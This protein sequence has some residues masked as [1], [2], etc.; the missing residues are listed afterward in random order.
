ML[1]FIAQAHSLCKVLQ[2]SLWHLQFIH[3][4][5]MLVIKQIWLALSPIL[6][7]TCIYSPFIAFCFT[8]WT[9]FNFLLQSK[10]VKSCYD[11]SSSRPMFCQPFG[12][13]WAD[14]TLLEL[15]EQKIMICWSTWV[16]RWLYCQSFRPKH[17]LNFTFADCLGFLVQTT[18]QTETVQLSRIKLHD[19]GWCV[20]RLASI[21]RT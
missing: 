3:C 4:N 17:N 10:E 5:M 1:Q 13:V 14:I 20:I 11:G 21:I 19:A 6:S 12:C 15:A 18:W 16:H 2:W 7:R 8:W 9:Q